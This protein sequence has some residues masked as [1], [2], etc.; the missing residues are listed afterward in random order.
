MTKGGYLGLICNSVFMYTC[1]C[2]CTDIYLYVC[3][4]LYI[5]TYKSDI[6]VDVD[7]LTQRAFSYITFPLQTRGVD[8]ETL[9][10]NSLFDNKFSFSALW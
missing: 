10:L 1:T 8:D 7:K 6:L 2:V 5:Y 9:Y 4:Y 3:I